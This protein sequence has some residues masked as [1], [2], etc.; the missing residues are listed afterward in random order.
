MKK[1][2]T[3]FLIGLVTISCNKY[4]FNEDESIKANS[5]KIFG[6]SFPSNQD[7]VTATKM[8]TNINIGDYSYNVKIYNSFFENLGGRAIRVGEIHEKNSTEDLSLSD[9]EKDSRSLPTDATSV[10]SVHLIQL[11]KY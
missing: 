9:S 2:L 1:L 4:S 11:L 6:V 8:S 5:E 7:W 3:L 10:Y